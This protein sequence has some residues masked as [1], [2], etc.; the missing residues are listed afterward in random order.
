[1]GI[2]MR[3]LPFYGIFY[4]RPTLIGVFLLRA[5]PLYR[6]FHA[7]PTLIW[8]FSCASYPYMGIFMRAPSSTD[9]LVLLQ[10]QPNW[11]VRVTTPWLKKRINHFFG[12]QKQILI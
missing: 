7:R 10:N 2:F 9:V 11:V 4:A 1:M 3:A 5:L 8:V 12:H 6:Y